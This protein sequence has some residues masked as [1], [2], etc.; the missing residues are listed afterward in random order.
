M[1]VLS[2]EGRGISQLVPSSSWSRMPPLQGVNGGSSPPGIIMQVWRNGRRTGLRV[3]GS[4]S[5]V[6]VQ[7]LSLALFVW[8][9]KGFDREPNAKEL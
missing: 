5:F 6:K 7:V 4:E 2:F 1:F 8:V 3:Q 9:R